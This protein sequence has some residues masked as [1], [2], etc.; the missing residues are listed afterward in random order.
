MIEIGKVFVAPFNSFT[1]FKSFCYAKLAIDKVTICAFGKSLG[2]IIK[3]SNVLS[4][5]EEKKMLA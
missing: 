3:K 2:K 5:D 1:N 4:I